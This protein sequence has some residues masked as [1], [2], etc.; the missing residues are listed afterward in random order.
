MV[1]AP[2][3][4]SREVEQEMKGLDANGVAPVTRCAGSMIKDAN[5]A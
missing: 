5:A 3:A 4:L 1:A 2:V